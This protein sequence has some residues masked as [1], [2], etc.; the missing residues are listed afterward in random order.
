ME[1]VSVRRRID[2]R[3]DTIRSLVTDTEAFM[4]AGGFE[5]VSVE[6]EQIEFT[7]GIGPAST[8]M[9]LRMVPDEDAVI[10]FELADGPLKE[11][12]GSYTVEETSTG[13]VVIAQAGI[14][15]TDIAISS[16]FDGTV[17]KSRLRNVFEAQVDY[18]EREAKSA[19]SD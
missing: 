9:R 12:N 10:A 13:T 19:E 7:T 15:L 5:D 6:D 11:F 3:A 17:L 4:E 16:L 14:Q 2:A 18:L 8:T 1:S